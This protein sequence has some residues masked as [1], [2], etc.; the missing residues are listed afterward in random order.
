MKFSDVFKFILKACQLVEH[1]WV[2]ECCLIQ[3]TFIIHSEGSVDYKYKMAASTKQ[4]AS[5]ARLFAIVRT[6]FSDCQ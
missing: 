5:L 3:G 4:D 6:I 1:A 2:H